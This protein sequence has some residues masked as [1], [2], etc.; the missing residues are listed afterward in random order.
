MSQDKEQFLINPFGL[1][2]S[3]VTASSLVKVDLSGNTLDPGST[4]LGCN[5][6]GYTLHSAI[7]EGRPEIQCV[8]HLHTGPGTAVS[9]MSCGLLPISQEALIVG[10]F[11]EMSL[12]LY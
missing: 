6:A 10:V 4:Q 12:L 8:I 3:E 2:Y 7:H 1:M 5:K 9:A 11:N